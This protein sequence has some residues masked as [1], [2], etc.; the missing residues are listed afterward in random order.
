MS[1]TFE[2]MA[3]IDAI[4]FDFFNTLARH[5]SSQGRG[6]TLM[7][8][9][10]ANGLASDPWEHQALYDVFERHGVEYAPD[11]S[12]QEKQEYYR[13]LASRLFHRLNVRASDDVAA[14][15]A[16]RLWQ[17]LGPACFTVFSEVSDVVRRLKA[18]GYRLAVV[19][20]W[21]CG[22]K[23]FCAELGIGESFDHVLASAEVGYAKPAPEI[24]HEA[25]RRLG[26][27]PKRVLHIGDTP[28]DDFD[29]AR[30]AGLQAILLRRDRGRSGLIAPSISSLTDV[31]GLLDLA[32]PKL[33]AHVSHSRE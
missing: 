8:Y 22:L 9:L 24:F 6:A 1:R 7:A 12:A 27:E 5:R 21:Q 23:H 32:G 29:G 25:C 14:K 33:Q 18:A 10:D 15:H 3:R 2:S 19:S 17:L 13:R 20:N 4:T 26:T 16:V 11:Q 31:L 30:S 28:V